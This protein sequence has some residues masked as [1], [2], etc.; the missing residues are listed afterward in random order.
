MREVCFLIGESGVLWSDAGE[1]PIAKE[2]VWDL[3]ELHEATISEEAFAVMMANLSP[4][5]VRGHRG[6]VEAASPRYMPTAL[7]IEVREAHGGAT[8]VPATGL[9]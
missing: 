6:P 5:A 8:V 1:S 4:D 7:A 9:R 2:A 3:M